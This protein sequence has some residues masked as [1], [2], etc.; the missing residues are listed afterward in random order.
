MN[1]KCDG[2]H[3]YM[4]RIS[5]KRRALAPAKALR[6]HIGLLFLFLRVTEHPAHEDHQRQNQHDSEH[7]VEQTAGEAESPLDEADDDDQHEDDCDCGSQ[8][9]DQLFQFFH[10]MGSPN[11]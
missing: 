8:N 2:N 6:F 10:W 11:R 3:A 1:R 4:I 7:G 9:G 5:I